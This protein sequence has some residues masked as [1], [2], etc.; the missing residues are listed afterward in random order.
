MEGVRGQRG[1]EGERRGERVH[2]VGG[3]HMSPLLI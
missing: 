1:G 2:H 3:A